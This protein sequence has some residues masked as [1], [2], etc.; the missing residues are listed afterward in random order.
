MGVYFR[1]V[2]RILLRKANQRD[3]KA[4]LQYQI[5]KAANLFSTKALDEEFSDFYGRNLGGQKA[6]Q[7]LEKRT[8]NLV[9]SWL[10]ELAGGIYVSRFFSHDDKLVCIG[11]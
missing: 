11:W 2:L 4:F 7:T 6:Q 10:G 3:V 5:I 1:R 8:L 9:N